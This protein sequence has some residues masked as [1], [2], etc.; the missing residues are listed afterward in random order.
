MATG[1][2]A[3]STAS[4]RFMI[5]TEGTSGRTGGGGLQGVAIATAAA[6]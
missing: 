4:C 2:T 5:A 3:A 1:M 6:A